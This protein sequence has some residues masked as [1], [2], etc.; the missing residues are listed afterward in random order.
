MSE[1][2]HDIQFKTEERVEKP[3]APN[4]QVN[5][6]EIIKETL[7]NHWNVG[8][9]FKD[10]TFDENVAVC[11]KDSIPFAIG[12]IN[13]TGELNVGMMIRTASLLGA[14]MVYIF[15]RKKFDKRSTVGAEHYIDI[16]QYVYD[17]PITADNEILVELKNLPYTP[18]V[19]E[20]GGDSLYGYPFNFRQRPPIFIFGSESHGIPK[21]IYES[22]PNRISIPQ[23][24]V[25]R[26]FNVSSAMSIVSWEYARYFSHRP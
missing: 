26:S 7:S 24:G 9:E 5:Y 8:D 10:N 3:K 14:E 20:Q 13:V 2:D 18:Y 12:I 11:R 6:A 22:I 23:R 1:L 19:I 25:L 4:P 17:D 15:G 21:F 16:R